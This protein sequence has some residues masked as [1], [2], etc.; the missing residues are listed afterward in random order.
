MLSVT[1]YNM[2]QNEFVLLIFKIEIVQSNQGNKRQGTDV[3]VLVG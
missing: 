2:R 3:G 1:V